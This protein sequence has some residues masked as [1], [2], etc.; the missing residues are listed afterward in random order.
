MVFER[1]DSLIPVIDL[2]YSSILSI[3]TDI[4]RI[5]GLN[6]HKDRHFAAALRANLE[7]IKQEKL[8]GESK[9]ED[10]RLTI[11]SAI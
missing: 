1:S 10:F 11:T 9:R 6:K 4:C 8:V 2:L 5:P 7:M 3:K